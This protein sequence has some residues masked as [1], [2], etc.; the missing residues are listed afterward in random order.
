MSLISLAVLS[1]LRVLGEPI[2]FATKLSNPDKPLDIPK[3][4]T[5]VLG[6]R[7]DDVFNKLSETMGN[8]FEINVLVV[9]EHV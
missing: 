9:F 5:A 1:E 8:S 4:A 3:S 6:N 2:D 7:G